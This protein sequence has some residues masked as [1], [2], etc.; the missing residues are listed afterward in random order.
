MSNLPT[1]QQLDELWDKIASYYNLYDEAREFAHAVLS[2][3]G[4]PDL[5]AELITLLNAIE[6]DVIDVN[7]RDRFE[8]AVNQAASAA[9]VPFVPNAAYPG[10]PAWAKPRSSYQPTPLTDEEID[11]RV[12][13][14]F[15]KAIDDGTIPKV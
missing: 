10:A 7:D 1:N 13:R 2:Q 14:A 8:A 3:F 15:I 5:R 11:A 9:A 6:I 4:A 12:R